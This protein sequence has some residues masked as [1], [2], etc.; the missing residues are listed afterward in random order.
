MEERL[1]GAQAGGYCGSTAGVGVTGLRAMG[2]ESR[3]HA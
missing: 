1:Q 2:M 3:G